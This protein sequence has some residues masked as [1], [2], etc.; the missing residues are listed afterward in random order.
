[1]PL[2]VIIGGMLGALYVAASILMDDGNQ[3][4]GLFF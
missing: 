1:M 2:V 4:A 3:L